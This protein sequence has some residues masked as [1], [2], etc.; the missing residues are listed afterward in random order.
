MEGREF[1]I[2]GLRTETPLWVVFL[3]LGA[4]ASL[5]WSIKKFF[6]DRY[7]HIVSL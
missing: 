3:N 1:S 7:W 2:H 4:N 5:K 6:D